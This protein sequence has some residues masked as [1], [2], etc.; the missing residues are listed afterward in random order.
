M[1]VCLSCRPVHRAVWKTVH[2]PAVSCCVFLGVAE[3]SGGAGGIRAGS[4][5]GIRS[6]PVSQ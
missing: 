5:E 4:Q 1:P 2:E 6:L 3:N